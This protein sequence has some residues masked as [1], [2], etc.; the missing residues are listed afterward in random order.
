RECAA[1]EAPGPRIRVI[2]IE[3]GPIRTPFRRNARARM[4]AM[5]DRSGS[6]WGRAWAEKILPRLEAEETE[7]LDR[8]ELT[9]EAVTRRLIH[10]LTARRPRPRY[11]VTAPTWIAAL[12]A[13]LLPTRALDLVFAGDH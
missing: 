8:F 11:Y 2:L 12:A 6:A 3:P 7:A 9:P 5:V 13:R 10:A 1:P 4:E